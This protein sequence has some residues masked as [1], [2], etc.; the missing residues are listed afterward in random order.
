MRQFK[1]RDFVIPDEL[2]PIPGMQLEYLV[3]RQDLPKLR[4]MVGYYQE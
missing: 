4:Y 3:F 2:G 1:C